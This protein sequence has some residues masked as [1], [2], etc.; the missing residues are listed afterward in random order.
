MALV[1]VSVGLIILAL[2]GVSVGLILLALLGVSVG[3]IIL[4]LVG[5][6]VICMPQAVR[7]EHCHSL[8]L[9][10]HL[11]YQIKLDLNFNLIYLPWLISRHPPPI[12]TTKFKLFHEAKL[13]YKWLIHRA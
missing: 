9:P 3:L 6:S 7:N 4:A 10:R 8:H 1:G 2:V 11:L 13:V 12:T 5:V